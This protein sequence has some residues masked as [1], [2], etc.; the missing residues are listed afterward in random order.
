[1]NSVTPALTRGK[2]LF[3]AVSFVLIWV[4]LLLQE[5]IT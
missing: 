5:I 3:L 4:L 1:M 2:Y